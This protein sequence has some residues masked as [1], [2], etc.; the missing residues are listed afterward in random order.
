METPELT[1]DEQHIR[2]ALLA[3]LAASVAALACALPW[4][5]FTAGWLAAPHAL[6]GPAFLSAGL[7]AVLRAYP[8]AALSFIASGWLALALKRFRLAAACAWLYLAYAGLALL[9][10]LAF[11]LGLSFTF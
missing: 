7:A 10:L 2:R 4:R 3:L 8:F 1:P 9:V 11:T 5:A 6:P